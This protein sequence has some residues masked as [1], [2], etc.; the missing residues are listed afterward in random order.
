MTQ[1]TEEGTAVAVVTDFYNFLNAGDVDRARSLLHDDVVAVQPPSVPYGGTF[2]GPDAVMAAGA[3]VRSFY[4]FS[5][6]DMHYIVGDNTNAV[7]HMTVGVTAIPTGK[8]FTFSAAECFEVREGKIVKIL[9]HH[10]D[11]VEVVK[12]FTAD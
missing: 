12:A 4:E 3:S 9:I 8:Q 10:F 11:T 1:Q 7:A 5:S 2:I 6:Y